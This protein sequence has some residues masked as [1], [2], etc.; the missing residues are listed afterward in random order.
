LNSELKI[1]LIR[2][3]HVQRGECCSIAGHKSGFLDYDNFFE[4]YPYITNII[5]TL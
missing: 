1:L 2:I 3:V 5:F 4:F